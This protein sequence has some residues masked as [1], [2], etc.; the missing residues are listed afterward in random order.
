MGSITLST[1]ITN[2]GAFPVD[3][4]VYFLTR[5]DLLGRDINIFAYSYYERMTITF[6][7]DGTEWVWREV[8][9]DD[10]GNGLLPS[11]FIYPS[12][13]N[14]NGI[15]YSS[16]IFNFFERT[17]GSGN[18]IDIDLDGNG[19][20]LIGISQDE[21]H[22]EYI[23]PQTLS[24]DLHYTHTQNLPSDYWTISHGL[25]KN[26]SVTVVDSAGTKVMGKI[27]YITQNILTLTFN[28]PFS[29]KAYL[30]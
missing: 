6:A 11:D 3:S 29:G 28:Y 10:N 5:N 25:N 9:S 1:S 8:G 26:A 15:D 16:R 4:K 27:D 2:N 7:D 13:L 14:Q 23:D 17:Y 21:T 19:E 24:V 22:L 12:N 18:L 20:K 30:N